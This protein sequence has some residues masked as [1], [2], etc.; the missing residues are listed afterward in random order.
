LCAL[1]RNKTDKNRI[2]KRLFDQFSSYGLSIALRFVGNKDDA[3]EVINDSFLKLFSSMDERMEQKQIKAFFRK[4][5]INTAIDH[6]RKA[7]RRPDNLELDESVRDDQASDAEQNLSAEEILNALK[8]LTDVQRYV[9]TLHEI[10]GYNHEEIALKLN[11]NISTSRSHLRRAKTKLQQI[12]QFYE[13][14]LG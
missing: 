3:L 12:L 13:R 1:K 2:Y 5:V 9:F 14:Q 6:Y 7:N 4:I 11:I 10:E 8:Q